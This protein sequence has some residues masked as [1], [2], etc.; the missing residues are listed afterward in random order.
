[1]ATDKDTQTALREATARTRGAVDEA[2]R[3]GESATRRAADAARSM[4]EDSAEA[5]RRAVDEGAETGRRA[6]DAGAD[7]TRRGA[8]TARDLAGTAQEVAN[9]TTSQFQRTFGLS[10]EAQGEVM[11]QARENM[12]VMVKCGSVLADGFQSIWK[13]WMGLAQEVATRNAS[14]VNSL[15]RSRSVPDFYATQ[16]SV[17]KENVQLV[18]DRSVKVSEL[19]ARTAHDAISKLANRAEDAARETGRHV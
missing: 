7:L 8:E 5:G 1:M 2:V 13:E 6:F 18:L 17:L 15:M 11:H 3:A 9:R 12:D 19:S 4:A 10:S 16:S 14:A